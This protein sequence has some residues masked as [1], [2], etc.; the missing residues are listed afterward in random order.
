MTTQRPPFTQATFGELLRRWRRGQGLK[1][2]DLGRLLVP[3]ARTSTVS[4]WEND[5]R[6]PSRRYMS[7]IVVLTGIPADVVLGV[8][9]TA[10]PG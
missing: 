5:L 6:I 9:T 1:Q 7:Q 10:G 8:A 3:K 2:D 4:C